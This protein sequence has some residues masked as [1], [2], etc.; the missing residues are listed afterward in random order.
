VQPGS[1]AEIEGAA[2]TW[3]IVNGQT[4]YRVGGHLLRGLLAL[5][6][7]F[8]VGAAAGRRGWAA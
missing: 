8:L 5:L 7:A 1:S 3:L 6:R 2:P 4:V